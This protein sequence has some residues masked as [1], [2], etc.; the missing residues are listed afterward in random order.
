MEVQETLLELVTTPVATSESPVETKP[1]SEAV[2]G[3]PIRK[4]KPAASDDATGNP[5]LKPINRDKIV[6]KPICPEDLV[7]P[8][9]PVRAMWDLLEL[10][11]LSSFYNAIRSQQG[12][13]GRPS[14]D[15]KMLIAV[16]LYAY[17]QGISSA[18]EIER[19][20]DHEPGLMWL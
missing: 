1:S 15:P 12:E 5:K 13:K 20:M 10:L 9:H 19:Q 18:R 16:W 3:K 7:E 14:N 2:I 11:D 4:G 8:G 17:S 6:T